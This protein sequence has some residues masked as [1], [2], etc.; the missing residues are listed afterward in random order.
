MTSMVSISF[1]SP[2]AIFH[3]VNTH[4]K[5]IPGDKAHVLMNR[6]TSPER[7]DTQRHLFVM[8]AQLTGPLSHANYH[9]MSITI[10]QIRNYAQ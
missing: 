10:F 8:I 2:G 7:V 4:S 3:H 5:W 1:M 9:I 6:A